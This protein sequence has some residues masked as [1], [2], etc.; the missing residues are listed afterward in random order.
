MKAL[1]RALIPMLAVACAAPATVAAGGWATVGLER[2]PDGLRPGEPWVASITVLQHARTPL[3][4]VHP[5]L[6]IREAGGPTRSFPAAPTSKP[7]VYR[8]R[9]VF[10][11]AGS[12]RYVVDDDFSARHR[13]GPVEIGQGKAA[14]ASVGAV[15]APES[16]AGRPGP[17]MVGVLAAAVL[18]L[19]LVFALARRR[20][21][22]APG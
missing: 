11:S 18:L 4:G 3:E 13:F 12:W 20:T 1:V 2:P 21:R 19:I 14:P 9:V 10:P 7:G 16:D 5:T 15:N 22:P 17:A 8:A 6:V